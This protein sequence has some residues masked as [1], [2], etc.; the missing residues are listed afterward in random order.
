MVFLPSPAL[1]KLHQLVRRICRHP[2]LLKHS[3][4]PPCRTRDLPDPARFMDSSVANRT[5]RH[6]RN[7][8]AG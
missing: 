7:Q 6:K 8:K 4:K 2:D 5:S 3:R 1:H